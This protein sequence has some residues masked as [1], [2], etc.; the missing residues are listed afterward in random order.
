MSRGIDAVIADA[1]SVAVMM[2]GVGSLSTRWMHKKREA[3]FMKVEERTGTK[4]M[5]RDILRQTSRFQLAI[6]N[7]SSS[8]GSSNNDS[9]SSSGE[10]KGKA[11]SMQRG[12][13][14]SGDSGAANNAGNENGTQNVS[15]SSGD[16]RANQHPSAGFHDYHAQPLPDPKI[17]GLERSSTAASDDSPEESST[18]A[19]D[20]KRGSTDSSSSGDDF[21]GAT[22]NPRL[23][24]RRKYESE[25]QASSSSSEANAAAKAS[26]PSL[27]H[28]IAK[29]GGI[30]HSVR[31][32]LSN[33][34]A[35]VDGNDRLFVAPAVPVPPFSGIGNKA[36]LLPIPSAETSQDVS[37]VPSHAQSLVI[38]Q[39]QIAV[40]DQNDRKRDGDA[41]LEGPA[42]ISADVETSSS[43]SSG[44]WPRIRAYYHVNEDDMVIM[45]DILMCPFVF[46]TQ[47][48]VL[49][50][51]QAECVMPGM[52]RGTFSSRNKLVS[53]EMIYDSMGFLQ[54]LERAS[55]SEATAQVI[56]GSLEMA[57][58]PPSDEARVIT[59]AEPPFLIV[60][61]NEAWT[62][63]TKY[64]QVD[65]EGLDLFGLLQ[66]E[67]E[68]KA[69]SETN[70]SPAHNLDDVI[71]GRCTCSTRLH[72][73]K[74]GREFVDFI[75][76]YPLTK[77]VT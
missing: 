22:K 57:L 17:T 76:S 59:L 25:Q 74:E 9:N 67:K 52:L 38:A 75:S 31:S 65:V 48:A 50:G 73:D 26:A 53:M 2:E 62:R 66:G 32:V 41:P 61:V 51:A 19:D 55:G 44:S 20:M 10:G 11:S 58:F 29:K 56:P 60:N 39:A 15:N 46:K 36:Q 43:N 42:V 71:Q 54:Q 30:S 35:F 6:S 28:N 68:E 23:L 1:A 24:K 16:D 3:F 72:Y 13:Q 37:Q 69:E 45:D 49:C 8:S 21:V 4:R 5:P 63:M 40:P 18:S 70:G 14:A 33:S 47:D 12:A 34:A 7:L 64:T 27:P 77:Y